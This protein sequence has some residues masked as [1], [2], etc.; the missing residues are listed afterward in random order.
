MS[1]FTTLYHAATN[2]DYTIELNARINSRTDYI[3]KVLE[4]FPNILLYIIEHH[5]KVQ[6]RRG[7]KTSLDDLI[8]FFLS[9][10]WQTSS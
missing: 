9:D 1:N 10:R 4:D 2:C 6:I 7:F 3:I 8:D 5:C